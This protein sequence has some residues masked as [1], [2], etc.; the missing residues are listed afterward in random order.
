VKEVRVAPHAAD[1]V[2]RAGLTHFL[3]SQPGLKVVETATPFAPG[4]I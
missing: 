2:I 4:V 1:S 3:Q